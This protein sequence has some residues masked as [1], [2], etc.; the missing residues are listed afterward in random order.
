MQAVGAKSGAVCT[1]LPRKIFCPLW[2]VFTKQHF[3]N[4]KADG[5]R[6]S[7]RISSCLL[8][9]QPTEL[10]G[11]VIPLAKS[12]MFRRSIGVIRASTLPR[13]TSGVAAT[14]LAPPRLEHTIQRVANG[15]TRFPPTVTAHQKPVVRGV[16]MAG[17]RYYGCRQCIF[18]ERAPGEGASHPA[19][20]TDACMHCDRPRLFC[21][22]AGEQLML[23]ASSALPPR[24]VLPGR[25]IV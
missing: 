12:S 22:A 7:N 11:T 2:S 3:S 25:G 15:V 18:F 20:P 14:G 4:P 5:K 17:S 10:V 23:A 13:S 24:L 9:T 1:L 21:R 8:T 16:P 19:T 6:G